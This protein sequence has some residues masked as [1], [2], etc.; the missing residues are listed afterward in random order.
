MVRAFLAAQRSGKAD[1]GPN[2]LVHAIAF[3]KG[4]IAGCVLPQIGWTPTDDAANYKRTRE[5]IEL[6]ASK[7]LIGIAAAAQVEADALG[8]NFPGTEH[9]LLALVR[10]HPDVVPDAERVR[11]EVLNIL[12]HGP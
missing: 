9:L 5:T 12:G 2:E 10:L 4:G 11:H 3:V 6:S 7:F 8:H 1:A